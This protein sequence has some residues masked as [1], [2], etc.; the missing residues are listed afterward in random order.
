LS[1]VEVELD[2]VAA[3]AGVD[4]VDPALEAVEAA[5]AGSVAFFSDAIAFF[6]ASE[7]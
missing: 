1:G 4:D 5:A 6:R 7:G 2:A 3:G